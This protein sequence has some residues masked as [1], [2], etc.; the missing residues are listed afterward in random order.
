MMAAHTSQELN[1]SLCMPISLNLVQTSE[2]ECN[3]DANAYKS[4]C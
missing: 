4:E 1:G 3:I 2:T